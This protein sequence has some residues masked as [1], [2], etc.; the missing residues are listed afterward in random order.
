[1][2]T[3]CPARPGHAT[4]VYGFCAFL[5][6][7]VKIKIMATLRHNDQQS[8]A[9]Q[10]SKVQPELQLHFLPLPSSPSLCLSLSLSICICVSCILHPAQ[11]WR[12][13]S[14]RQRLMIAR[15]TA[16]TF[17]FIGA[18]INNLSGILRKSKERRLHFWPLNSLSSYLNYATICCK[19]A[20]HFAR[21]CSLF[22]LQRERCGIEYDLLTNTLLIGICETMKHL[23]ISLDSTTLEWLNFIGVCM[24]GLLNIMI[25]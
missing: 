2:Y 1:M 11:P 8:C 7:L 6:S 17:I 13:K 20:L 25:P 24:N 21:A 14:A 23:G 18:E 5:A 10:A 19:V 3:E 22:R 4:F 12:I 16:D 15:L 9:A